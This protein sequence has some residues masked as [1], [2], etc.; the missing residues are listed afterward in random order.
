MT[1]DSFWDEPH[2]NELALV[3]QLANECLEQIALG[4]DKGYRV[5]LEPWLNACPGKQAKRLFLRMIDS[6]T[7][8]S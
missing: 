4:Q 2:P 6:P 7:A 8:K 3:G 5:P 1:R